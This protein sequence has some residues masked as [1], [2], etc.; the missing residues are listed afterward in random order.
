MPAY[1][2]ITPDEAHTLIPTAKDWIYILILALACTVYA[3]YFSIKILENL[4]AFNVN[5]TV[6]LEPVYGIVLA[7]AIYG[8]SEKMTGGFYLGTLVILLSVLCYPL[9]D[10]YF[11]PKRVNGKKQGK[12]EQGLA[13]EQIRA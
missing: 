11:N 2:S 13:E 10:R 5:L 1:F 7:V 9:L 3:F 8:E 12:R 4:S 6:N